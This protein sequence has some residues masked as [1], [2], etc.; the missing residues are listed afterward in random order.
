[1]PVEIRG[2]EMNEE[3]IQVTQ[4][5]LE[6]LMALL[7]SRLKLRTRDREHL[8][9]LAQELDRAEIV[10]SRDIP[11]DTVTMH[12]HVLV[13]DLDTGGESTYTL[14][15]PS[16]ADIEIGKISILAPIATALLGYREGDEI[17][18]PTP[19]GRRRL[20]V[21]QVLY[22]PEAA[23]DEPGY[24]VPMRCDSQMKHENVEQCQLQ[25]VCPAEEDSFSVV[26]P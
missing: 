13:R 10:Q 19:G 20:N 3:M 23:G 21:I 25:A 17:E 26:S 9:M 24:S 16:D 2:T 8:E 7:A 14:V 18:W 4:G 12:S 6:K 22:Q 5:D 15:Y 1:M 11:A